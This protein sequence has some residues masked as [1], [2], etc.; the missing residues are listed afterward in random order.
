MREQAGGIQTPLLLSADDYHEEVEDLSKILDIPV[1]Y[2]K[3]RVSKD[4]RTRINEHIKFS[5]IQAF[6]FFPKLDKIIFLE[7][8]LILS[9]DFIRLVYVNFIFFIYNIKYSKVNFE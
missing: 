7:D 9:P 5:I 6:E 8:D 2:H 1:V 3:D 4:T